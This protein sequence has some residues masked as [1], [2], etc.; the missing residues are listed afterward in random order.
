MVMPSGSSV[1]RETVGDIQDL[2]NRKSL[3]HKLFIDSGAVG[4]G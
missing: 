1:T 3:L 4:L 2:C